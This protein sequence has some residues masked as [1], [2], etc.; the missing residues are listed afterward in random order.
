MN[1]TTPVICPAGYYCPVNTKTSTEYPCPVG[2]FSNVI[3]LQNQSS[4]TPCTA[5]M[6][7]SSTALTKPT[8]YCSEGYYCGGGSVSST[9]NDNGAES[10]SLKLKYSGEDICL[11]AINST[12]LNDI[13][14]EGHYCPRGSRSPIQCP[15]GTNSSLIGLVNITQCGLCTEG[16]YCPLN[17][18][19][20]ATRKCLAGYY[21]PKGTA[22]L[23]NNTQL[24]CPTGS[25]CPFGSASPISCGSGSYN[26][27]RFQS[28]CKVRSY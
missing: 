12:T 28:T 7:C 17:G 23:G 13:C 6:Y 14:P 9:P 21:C 27:D 26:D 1:T 20:F 19:I 22:N 16:Y 15:P 5:G 25:Y 24:L 3:G 8:N 11:S 2:T 18:T 10:Y 4:C